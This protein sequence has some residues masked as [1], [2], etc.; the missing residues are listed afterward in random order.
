MCQ[1]LYSALWFVLGALLASYG[2][3]R[4]LH[5]ETEFVG[6]PMLMMVIGFAL[7]GQSGRH[8]ERAELLR[9]PADTYR[10]LKEAERR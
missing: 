8:S 7:V 10:R 2:A 5:E 4:F 9:R 1:T 3:F 6:V